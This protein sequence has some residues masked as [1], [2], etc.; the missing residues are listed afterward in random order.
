MEIEVK[1]AAARVRRSPWVRGSFNLA[2]FV[3]AIGIT[4][5]LAQAIAWYLMLPIIIASILVVTVVGALQLR[6]NERLSQQTFLELMRLSFCQ[7]PLVRIVNGRAGEPE[8]REGI[9][10]D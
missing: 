3:C 9:I 7:L 8:Q 5:W 6:S 10:G 1:A 4:G 2:I